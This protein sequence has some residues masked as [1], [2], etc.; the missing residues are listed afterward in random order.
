[1][2]R[3]LLAFGLI[4]IASTSVSSSGRVVSSAKQ[5][6]PSQDHQ[7]W[8]VHALQKMETVRAGMTRAELLKTFTTEGGLSTG[9]NRRFVSQDCPYFKVDVEYRAVGRSGKDSEGRVTL[10]EDSRDIIVKISQPYL[11]FSIGD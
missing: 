4:L 3:Q 10:L 1:M 7:A 6:Q 11:Q 9:L 8:V 5:E 2:I